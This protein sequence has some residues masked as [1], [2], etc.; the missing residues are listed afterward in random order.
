LI[1]D[2]IIYLYHES[3]VDIQQQGYHYRYLEKNA[4]S[5]PWIVDVK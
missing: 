1:S 4:S 3:M 5:F 2:S